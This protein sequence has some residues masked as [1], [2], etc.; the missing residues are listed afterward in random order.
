[1]LLNLSIKVSTTD[2]QQFWGAVFTITLATFIVVT[3]EMLPIGL[4]TPIASQFLVSKSAVGLLMTLPAITA[5]LSAPLIILFTRSLNRKILLLFAAIL[6]MIC[7]LIAASTPHFNILLISR[8]F[9]GICI[10]IIWAIAGGIASRLVKPSRIN[11]ATS[12]IFG[13]VAAASVIGVPLGVMVSEW[14]GWRSAFLVM[15]GLSFILILLMSVFLPSLPVLSTPTIKVFITQI[16]RPIISIGLLITFLLVSG[17]FV[18]FTYVQPLLSTI[19]ISG[20]QLGAILLLYGLA[21]IL[22]NFIF[23][24][25]SG[26]RLTLTLLIITLGILFTLF[27][28]KL[29][30]LNFWLSSINMILW[31]FAYGGVSVSLMTWMIVHSAKNIEITSSLY[32]TFFNMGIA[33]GSALGSIA[34]SFDGLSANLLIAILLILMVLIIIFISK[35][36]IKN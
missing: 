32:I 35:I 10:G 7:N 5:A 13:G 24:I 29:M 28:F 15:S 2:R 4:I 8:I 21:G 23:G 18:A 36:M 22:G 30:P 19:H 11:I 14:L 31:G 25:S 1:M 9:V 33:I 12:L 16:K 27:I 6:L 20:E 34:V 17:H 3:T 26:K